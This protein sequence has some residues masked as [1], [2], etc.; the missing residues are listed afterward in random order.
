MADE[1]N[2]KINP[3]GLTNRTED[4][5]GGIGDGTTP[6][7]NPPRPRPTPIVFLLII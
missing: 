1:N 7:P 2:N 6:I 4:D 5:A 3:I